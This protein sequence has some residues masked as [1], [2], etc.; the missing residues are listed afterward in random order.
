MAWVYY[1]TKAYVLSF[2]EALSE[3]A[4]GSS[5]KVTCL[6]PGPTDTEFAA[7]ASM[8][9]SGLFNRGAMTADEVADAGFDG[10]YAGKRI[11][12]RCA[13]PVHGAC[14][15]VSSTR[16]R[17]QIGQKPEHDRGWRKGSRHPSAISDRIHIR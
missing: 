2:T 15:Q 6:A 3:E 8:T 11:V 4:V 14:G 7:E 1:A 10:W 5:L 12:I 9:G 13:Q 17:R 16:G